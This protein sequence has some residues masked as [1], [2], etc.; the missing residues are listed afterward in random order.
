MVSSTDNSFTFSLD[1]SDRTVASSEADQKTS[2][3]GAFDATQLDSYN[4]NMGACLFDFRLYRQG[5]Q[6]A[7]GVQWDGHNVQY[8]WANLARTSD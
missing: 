5:G 8:P 2:L 6:F 1:I 4:A 3:A 7:W